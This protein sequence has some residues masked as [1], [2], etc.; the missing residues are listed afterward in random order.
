MTP[1]ILWTAIFFIF[2]VDMDRASASYSTF[3]F[4]QDREA[5]NANEEFEK[6]KSNTT[7]DDLDDNKIISF[8]DAKEISRESTQDKF[9]D[10][11]QH[12][13]LPIYFLQFKKSV[14]QDL[15]LD[16]MVTFSD[17]GKLG[18]PTKHD[19]PRDDGMNIRGEK[20][21]EFFNK[22]RA[23]KFA[24]TSLEKRLLEDLLKAGQLVQNADGSIS[25]KKDF[26]IVSS[27]LDSR[28]GTGRHECSHAHYFTDPTYR[29]GINKI[30]QELSAE[31][32][33][34][35]ADVLK[36]VGDHTHEKGE[37]IF[38]TEFGAYFRDPQT[39]Y[40]D[41][42]KEVKFTP[43]VKRVI[44]SSAEKILRFEA[45]NGGCAKASGQSPSGNSGSAMKGPQ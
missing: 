26:A 45:K 32:K 36:K 34:I 12:S 2:A 28:K 15:A 31:E 18:D 33:K 13:K 14:Y 38:Y 17:T 9:F 25:A 44:E 11:Y 4:K 5:Y 41:Y 22:M 39:L 3:L 42:K 21:A 8:C 1:V 37:D 27:S 29:D 43:E 6:Q 16:R 7:A 30:Y 20:V 40:E 23:G 24:L 10:V 35:V 19:L